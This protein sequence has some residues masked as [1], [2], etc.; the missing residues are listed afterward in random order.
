MEKLMLKKPIYKAE[1]P[2]STLDAWDRHLEKQMLVWSKYFKS[3]EEAE[4]FC[5][6]PIN[7]KQRMSLLEVMKDE[8]KFE[9]E[10]L[11]CEG[12][13]DTSD[14]HRQRCPACV[15]LKRPELAKPLY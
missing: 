14:D 3:D 4:Y 11:E 15:S 8:R 7:Y 12:A 10:L 6:L 2:P 13:W 5:M 9:R 1:L